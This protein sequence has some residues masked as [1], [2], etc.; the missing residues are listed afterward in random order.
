[1]AVER[2]ARLVEGD[3]LG[4]RHRQVRLRHRHDA[5]V[6]AMDDRD[7]AAPVALARDA[8]VAQAEVDLAL[9]HWRLP[10]A[11]SSRAACA[12]SSLASAMRHAVEEARIDHACRRRHRRSSVM[13]KVVGSCAGRA[14]HRRV[15]EA[16]FVG[17]VE[18]A[19]VVRRAAEDRAGAVVH[20]DEV[21]DVDRQLSSSAS[22]GWTARDAG[23]EAQLLGGL[24]RRL[25]GAVCAG[26]RR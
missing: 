25:R 1:M 24:D 20:Q 4:Q 23:V 9:R 7:R 5:A 15:A 6:V 18:V 26:T 21:G 10:R 3:V 14:H 17:E 22:N 16:V 2:I 8:P 12:T 11:S 13:T 19:L